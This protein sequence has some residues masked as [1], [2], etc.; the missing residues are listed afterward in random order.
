MRFWILCALLWG[1][2]SVSVPPSTVPDSELTV[3]A[4]VEF[5]WS[6]RAVV[7]KSTLELLR[8]AG[9]RVNVVYD[10]DM[11]DIGRLA[12][13]INSPRLSKIFSDAQ[14]V[15][16][17][18]V[19][20]KGVTFG[21]M[22]LRRDVYIVRDRIWTDVMLQHVLEHELLHLGGVEHVSDESAVMYWQTDLTHQAV[23]LTEAD[24]AAIRKAA[25]N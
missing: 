18:D 8:Q 14:I 11:N 2:S 25:K 22:G 7:R 15:K 21:W 1:C 20:V 13:L 4:D 10:L 17:V 16:D 6:E 12:V 24:R 23:M 9:Y 3:H 5:D 19:Q